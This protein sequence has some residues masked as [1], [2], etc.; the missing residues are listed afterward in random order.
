MH[1]KLYYTW[2]NNITVNC[3]A[4]EDKNYDKKDLRKKLYIV[5]KP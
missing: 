2:T 5:N 3:R 4:E 1:L